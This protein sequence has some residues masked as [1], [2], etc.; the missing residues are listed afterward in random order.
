M[1]RLEPNGV[2]L[3][4]EHTR[5]H[6]MKIKIKDLQ[7]HFYTEDDR[8]Y[9][10]KEIMEKPIVQGEWIPYREYVR[11]LKQLVKLKN[12]PTSKGA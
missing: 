2:F 5:S 1:R 7:R 11:V 8:F 9:T 6:K 12:K 4:S 10:T 3:E